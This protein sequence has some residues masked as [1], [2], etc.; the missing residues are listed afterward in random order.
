MAARTWC[1]VFACA[2][3]MTVDKKAALDVAVDKAGAFTLKYGGETWFTGS[4]VFLRSESKL[5]STRDGSLERVSSATS[6][7]ADGYGAFRATAV[8]WRAGGGA[9][10][11]TTVRAYDS[12][13]IFE[14][15]LP[16]GAN[17]T[18][19][20]GDGAADGLVTG[21]P[22]LEVAGD[23][24]FVHW[25]GSM[26]GAEAVVGATSRN[27]S[28]LLAGGLENTS[29]V[30]FFKGGGE[31]SAVASA[32]SSFMSVNHVAE[33]DNSLTFGLMGRVKA[34]APGHSVETIVHFAAG[35]GVNGAMDAWG[36]ALLGRYGKDRGAAAGDF[37]TN[38]LGYSTDNGA[39][40]YYGSEPN[41]TMEQTILDVKAYADEAGIPYRHVLLDSWWYYQAKDTGAVT[42]WTARPDVFPRGMRF[43]RDRTGWPIVAHNRYWSGENVYAKQN[44]GDFDFIV[45]ASTD[46]KHPG[47]WAFPTDPRFWDALIGDA[48]ADWG[49]AT[50]EQDWLFNEFSLMAAPLESATLAR[51]WLL[52]MGAAAARHDV[53]IQYCTGQEKGDSTSL[54]RGCS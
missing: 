31:A 44:G 1:L 39:F 30:A 24:G 43:L 35:V 26:T 54:Q 53:T 29:P 17:G 2:S 42:N 15:R 37:T 34:I 3:A 4:E 51:S 25:R 5:Y 49:L 20:S 22:R 40:Y 12:M 7:G 13:V 48:A 16:D 10:L 8:E 6:T 18:A 46:E 45:E 41:K 28:A 21:W 36:A 11:R 33:D 32:A 14:Q 23:R 27:F 47:S 19:C 52:E 50:Y 38:Y 9:T